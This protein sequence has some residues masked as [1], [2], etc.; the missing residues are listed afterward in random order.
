ML[1]CVSAGE[2]TQLVRVIPKVS[3]AMI[4]VTL[5]RTARQLDQVKAATLTRHRVLNGVSANAARALIRD[6]SA[7]VAILDPAA[8]PASQTDDALTAG[9]FEIGHEF[10]YLPVV[11]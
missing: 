9:F 4:V 6:N 1:T 8:R 3:I 10:P 5:L 11:F 2:D 7:D